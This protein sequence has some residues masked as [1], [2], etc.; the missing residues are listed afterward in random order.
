MN[1]GHRKTLADAQARTIDRMSLLSAL[2]LDQ[3]MAERAEPR[4]PEIGF[5]KRELPGERQWARER[6]QP[7]EIE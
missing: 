4:L 2:E 1:V 3:R 7:K 5:T 6:I